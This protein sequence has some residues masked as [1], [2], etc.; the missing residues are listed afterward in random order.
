MYL[1][2]HISSNPFIPLP[3]PPIVLV[4]SEYVEDNIISASK[5]LMHMIY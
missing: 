4:N 3:I 1:F 2:Y 5:Y